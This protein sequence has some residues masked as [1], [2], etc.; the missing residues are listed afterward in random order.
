MTKPQTFAQLNVQTF[1]EQWAPLA[2]IYMNQTRLPQ[3]AP[4]V[5]L[6]KNVTGGLMDQARQAVYRKGQSRYK[7]QKELQ[8]STL[9][10]QATVSAGPSAATT[11]ATG[12]GGSGYSGAPAAQLGHASDPGSVNGGVTTSPTYASAT[13]SQFQGATSTPA[14]G[15]APVPAQQQ[16]FTAA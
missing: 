13:P 11:A 10:H 7:V 14:P 4:L 15:P 3:N 5:G 16:Q 8:F 2:K 9:K 12:V 6:P 1:A